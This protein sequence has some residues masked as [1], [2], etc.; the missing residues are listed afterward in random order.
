M[1]S[2]FFIAS[3][4][5]NEVVN[6]LIKEVTKKE[7]HVQG[8]RL[9]DGNIFYAD[10]RIWSDTFRQWFI[11]NLEKDGRVHFRL[12]DNPTLELNTSI[13]NGILTDTMGNFY[14]L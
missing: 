12:K 11:G 1:G 6:D 10:N 2:I 9:L 13:N 5:Q 3:H 14:S 4:I 8:R 7:E